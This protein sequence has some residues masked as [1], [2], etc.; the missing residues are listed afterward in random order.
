M[1]QRLERILSRV[2]K[3][4]RYAGGEYNAVMKNKREAEVHLVFVFQ[5]GRAHV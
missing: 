4:A 1:D 2:Q 5:I 3:P